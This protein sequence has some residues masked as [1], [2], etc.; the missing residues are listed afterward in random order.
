MK[1]THGA[2]LL[3]AA[4]VASPLVLGLGIVFL[5]A[6][7][8]EDENRNDVDFTLSSGRLRVGQD[9][10][11]AQYAGLIE[12]AAAD[13]DAGLPAGILAAQIK[14]ESNWDPTAQS[15]EYRK[16]PDTGGTVRI[17][18]AKGIAQFIDGTWASSGIDGNKDG[19]KD[20]WDPE[21]AIPSQGK[22]MCALLKTAKKH[23]DYNGSPIELAL[24]GYNAGWGRVQ[25][26][27]GVPPKSFAAGQTHNYVNAI[28]AD[29]AR[30]TAPDTSGDPEL[31]G[32]WG[33]PVK[34]ALGTP[35]HQSG[36]MWSSGYHTG[37]DFTVP[38]GTA[39]HT[40]GPG[41]V[42]AAGSG[43][44]YGNQVVIRHPDGMFSQYAHMTQ[45]KVSKGQSV[46]GGQII[47]LSGATGNV[48]GPHLHME[49]RTGPDYG[50]DVSPL[51]YLRRKGIGI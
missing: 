27:K 41:K 39:I 34:A 3:A 50:T 24:A 8:A 15:Y 5:V 32:G 12:K 36:S 25:Q 33:R 38:P 35:Y 30:L 10:V 11:P 45:I 37:I 28:M 23:P 7:A 29:V 2:V 14:A 44:S 46:Q 9:H 4:A 17:P 51:P 40:I 19:R 49:V 13:C 21:D 18:L 20:V 43:G 26:Y 16:D 22:M 6:V 1:L 47:G 31:S 48:T 42:V